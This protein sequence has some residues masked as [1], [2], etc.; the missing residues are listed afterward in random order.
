MILIPGLSSARA[1]LVTGTHFSTEQV[2]A[3]SFK[4]MQLARDAGRK[5][6]FD[7]DYRPNLWA[8]GGH[9]DGE[10]RFAESDAVTAHLQRVLPHC[11]LIVGTE[12]ECISLAAYRYH[13]GIAGGTQDRDTILVCKR[14]RSAVLFLKMLSLAGQTGSAR[15]CAKSK[16][17]MSSVPVMVLCQVPVRLAGDEPLARCALYANI[18]GAL[19]VSRH[20]CAPPI[21]RRLSCAIWLRKAARNLPC[22]KIASCHRS[23]GRQHAVSRWKACLPLPLITVTSLSKW[24]RPRPYEGIDGSSQSRWRRLQP[25]PD[26]MM[27]SACWSMTSLAGRH[28][29]RRLIW[30]SGSAGRLRNQ[31]LSPWRLKKADL[32]GGSWNGRLIIASRFLRF[33]S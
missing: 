13:H 23:T 15:R 22:G 29:M 18:C 14:G 30:A 5:V 26:S 25:L 3:A 1:V 19:A 20:G 10:S 6:A 28:C 16:C 9:A 11:D 21:P 17:S 4:A 31:A 7:I 24:Q 27:V 12:E 8:L 33:A 32:A 2:A